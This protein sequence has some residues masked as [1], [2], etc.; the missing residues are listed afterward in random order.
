MRLISGP[1]T[2]RGAL[3]DL[4]HG[5]LDIASGSAQYRR[6]HAEPEAGVAAVC[7]DV[8]DLVMVVPVCAEPASFV[9]GYASAAARAGRLLVIAV[10]NGR[11]TA[12]DWVH[13]AN[14]D[15]FRELAARFSLSEIW[16]GGWIGRD[17][18]TTMLVVDRFTSCRR[19]PP[20]QGVG[21]ARKIGADI[22][23]A[24]TAAGQ[25]RSPFIAMMDADARLPDDYFERIAA[26]EPDC[27]A[28]LFPFWH[29]PSGSPT[30]D[31]ATA[32][33]EI[34]LRYVQRGLHW[35]HSPFAFHSMGSTMVLHALRYA[36]VRG[37]PARLA[38][39]DFYLLDKLCKVRPIVRLHGA[40][41]HIRSRVSDRVPF[42][43][44][45]ETGKLAG[46]TQ[47]ELYHPDCFGAVREVTRA[48]GRLSRLPLDASDEP[49]S[50]LGGPVRTFLESHGAPAVWQALREHAPNSLARL[51]HLHE[52]FNGFRTLKLIHAV[53]DQ[54]SPSLGWQNALDQAPFM[55][56]ID[57]DGDCLTDART[58]LLHAE[59]TQ[60][61]LVGPSLYR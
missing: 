56:V 58:Q 36:H 22:A 11:Q 47:L 51:R 1:S 46:R 27:S 57:D 7:R 21:L 26:L 55:E 9:D 42:G 38:A 2:N 34:R 54:A 40:P 4:H 29:E 48:L 3:H 8:F 53:R 39:E 61:R 49:L 23:L 24:L 5:G 37:V 50:Q 35:A 30:V 31:R 20:R 45:A 59:Q 52:W 33:Y 32:L 25:I 28:A 15:C 43:T 19:L 17:R 60:P 18:R 10:L 41:I 16:D 6:R 14:A 44:G 13:T 12:D